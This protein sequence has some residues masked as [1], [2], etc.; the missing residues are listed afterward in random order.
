MLRAAQRRLPG[1]VV[2]GDAASLPFRDGGAAVVCMIWLLHI[3]DDVDSV[4]AE[5]VRVLEPGGR[6]LTTVDKA[7]AHG[8][9]TGAATDSSAAVEATLADLG[10]VPAGTTTFV[11]LGQGRRGAPD[12]VFTLR[13]FEKQA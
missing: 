11:G 3:V 4:L 10:A 8:H 13:A 2:R 7:A 6:L 12:P 9:R 1:R 5:A